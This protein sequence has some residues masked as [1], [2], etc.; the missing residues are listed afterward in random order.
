LYITYHD[1]ILNF[2]GAKF[3]TFYVG[4]FRGVEH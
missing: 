4:V 3:Y 2:P 1:V